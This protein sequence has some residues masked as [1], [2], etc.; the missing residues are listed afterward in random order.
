MAAINTDSGEVRLISSGARPQ[1]QAM[2]PD[3]KDLVRHER[4]RIVDLDSRHRTKNAN[5]YHSDRDGAGP[6]GAVTG[7]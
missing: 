6:C 7:R 1:G 5:R 4:R 3:R 2:S